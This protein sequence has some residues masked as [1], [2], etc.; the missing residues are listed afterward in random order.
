MIALTFLLLASAPD[1]HHRRLD[2]VTERRI[3]R[4]HERRRDEIERRERYRDLSSKGAFN[5][6][7]SRK[8][9]Y[10]FEEPDDG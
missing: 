7:G 2:P 1:H 3:E 6:D 10:D 8:K 9:W 5:E 4:R